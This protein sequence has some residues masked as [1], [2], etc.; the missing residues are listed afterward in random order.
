MK[1]HEA[2]ELAKQ[3]KR[4]RRN[5]WVK[6]AYIYQTESE[7][8]DNFGVRFYLTFY[9][10]FEADDWEVYEEE[11]PK[12]DDSPLSAPDIHKIEEEIKK[13]NER[14]ERIENLLAFKFKY[15]E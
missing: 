10:V 8:V 5:N 12:L 1:L 6:G 4:I 13:L 15:E 14:I 3:D 2:L 9:H 7:I 11:K